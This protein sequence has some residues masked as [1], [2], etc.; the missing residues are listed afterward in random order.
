[1]TDRRSRK[2]KSAIFAALRT[3]MASKNYDKITVQDIIETAD[4]GRSTFY[5]HFEMKDEL[6]HALCAD[7][8]NHVF[9]WDAST[10]HDITPPPSATLHDKLIHTFS[11]LA[12]PSLHLRHILLSDGQSVFIRYFKR[13]A[14]EIFLTYADLDSR[15]AQ[16]EYILSQLSASLADTLIWWLSSKESISASEITENYLSLYPTALF[17]KTPIQNT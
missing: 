10:I 1:M 14:R 16:K 12:D 9:Q 15:P 6:L 5:T 17:K 3:L 7:I 2:T 11:H 13:Y 4:I 8:F